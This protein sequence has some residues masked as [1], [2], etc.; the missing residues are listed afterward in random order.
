MRFVSLLCILA[1]LSSA[2]TTS[3]PPA[4]DNGSALSN[5]ITSPENIP[6]SEE[7]PSYEDWESAYTAAIM[8]ENTLWS[9]SIMDIDGDSVP[10]AVVWTDSADSNP[11]IT[12]IYS[13][14][15]GT[16]VIWYDWET[17]EDRLE[18]IF[19]V[20]YGDQIRCMATE[21]HSLTGMLELGVYELRKSSSSMGEGCIV[22][23]I[24][25]KTTCSWNPYE[26]SD[27]IGNEAVAVEDAQSTLFQQ[28]LTVLGEKILVRR[29]DIE[30]KGFDY[31]AETLAKRLRDW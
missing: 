7:N 3:S 25:S 19:F 1:L 20:Q 27:Q 4:T 31:T 30:P 28:T 6:S 9:A 26:Y 29:L 12:R 14:E 10:E 23:I 21:H 5:I 18:D 8:D 16:S 15:N 22:P 13:Y 2:C 24:L 17:S 11:C